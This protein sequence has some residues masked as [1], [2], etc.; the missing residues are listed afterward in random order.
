MRFMR[1]ASVGLIVRA[2]KPVAWCGTTDMRLEDEE[3]VVTVELD[4]SLTGVRTALVEE[5]RVWSVAPAAVKWVTRG[6]RGAGWKD[7]ALRFRTE[8][9]TLGSSPVCWPR[10][11]RRLLVSILV[12]SVLTLR[13]LIL[14][15]L[16]EALLA[17]KAPEL[18]DLREPL[19]LDGL[20]S[21]DV[22]ARL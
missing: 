22:C 12:A 3:G 19:A 6:S 8:V 20:T 13:A 2:P 4:V 16:A 15:R 9:G 11:R 7:L 14:A 5:E 21:L 10:G 17:P 18:M 1:R